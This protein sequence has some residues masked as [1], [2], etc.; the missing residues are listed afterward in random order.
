MLQDAARSLR[1]FA[2]CSLQLPPQSS[3][4][5]S[6]RAFKEAQLNCMFLL[7]SSSGRLQRAGEEREQQSRRDTRAPLRSPVRFQQGRRAPK[8]LSLSLPEWEAP[9]VASELEACKAET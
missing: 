4:R 2:A 9:E 5:S 8:A 6:L 7:H 1:F 3:L